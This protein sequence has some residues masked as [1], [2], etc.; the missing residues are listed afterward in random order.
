M[1]TALQSRDRQLL[2][3][4]GAILLLIGAIRLLDSPESGNFP[5]FSSHSAAKDGAKA[6]YLLLQESGTAVERWDQPLA[7]LPPGSGVVLI[8]AA[9]DV[10]QSKLAVS[11]EKDAL[12]RFL[13]SG[14]R[15]IATGP[16]VAS[17]L[18][19]ASRPAP[20]HED[21]K[22]SDE[23]ADEDESP[24]ETRTETHAAIARSAITSG[25]PLIEMKQAP[26]PQVTAK[27]RVMEYADRAVMSYHVE[28]GEV[29]WWADGF[30]LT[31]AGIKRV[32]NLELFLNSV[33]DTKRVLWDEHFHGETADLAAYL[34]HTPVPWL[35][36]QLLVVF[37]AV[38]FTFGRRHGP[39]VSLSS[40][41]TRLSPLEFVETLGDLYAR[42]HAAPEALETAYQ[43]FRYLAAKRLGI[44]PSAPPENLAAAAS[45][46]FAP[47]P[48]LADLL[49]ECDHAE[50]FHDVPE[51]RA[52]FLV[53]ELHS[54][55]T[56]WGL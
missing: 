28:S 45:A 19:Q 48:A 22:P 20:L 21:K 25:A 55:A 43:R 52:L 9:P 8:L 41:K 3:V 5:E 29:I 10:P 53:G 2:I 39:I 26:M 18:P 38:L 35:E 47:E 11:E 34:S 44:S 51:K 33:G 32:S 23:E 6:A 36:A 31:N 24:K 12:E 54:L 40:G 30:P 7:R 56:K 1:P 49:R 37:L 4:A 15:V 17:I 16:D 13:R 14:G 46:R 27:S 50:R 42:K